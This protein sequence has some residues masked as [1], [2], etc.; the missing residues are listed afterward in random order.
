MHEAA[1]F[2]EL[3]RRI[4]ETDAKGRTKRFVYDKPLSTQARR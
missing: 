3:S 2:D 4:S 1:G